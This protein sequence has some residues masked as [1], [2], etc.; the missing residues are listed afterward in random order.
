MRFACGVLVTADVEQMGPP[1]TS[2]LLEV[3][4]SDPPAPRPA[5]QPEV[6]G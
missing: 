6:I 4:T 3:E 2:T 1:T 5:D